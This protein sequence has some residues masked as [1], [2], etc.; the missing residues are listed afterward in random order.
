MRWRTYTGYLIEYEIGEG[1]YVLLDLI[2][3]DNDDRYRWTIVYAGD[4]LTELHQCYE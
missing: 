3:N 4:S 2:E 1:F